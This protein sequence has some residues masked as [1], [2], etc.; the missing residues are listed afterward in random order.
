[1]HKALMRKPSKVLQDTFQGTCA[2]AV[3]LLFGCSVP[4]PGPQAKNKG[5]AGSESGVV[6]GAAR[7]TRGIELSEEAAVLLQEMT[8][9]YQRLKIAELD[10]TVWARFEMDDGA[11]E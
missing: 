6:S 10:G 5:A 7:E 2:L 9:A 1:M 3:V 8:T 4:T 11:R